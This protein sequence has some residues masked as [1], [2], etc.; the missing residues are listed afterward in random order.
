MM[1][2]SL[3]VL[4]SLLHSVKISRKYISNF[5]FLTLWFKKK[6]KYM[7]INKKKS[8]IFYI[9]LFKKK[10]AQRWLWEFSDFVGTIRSDFMHFSASCDTFMRNTH[11]R[12]IFEWA[13]GEY[14]EP[15]ID[16]LCS[17]PEWRWRFC[18]D[19]SKWELPSSQ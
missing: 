12:Q 5:T 18:R 8:I 1:W 17:V 3:T 14:F 11:E 13:I 15:G 6:K 16:A 10:M 9:F 2:L 4:L 19:W 7:Y